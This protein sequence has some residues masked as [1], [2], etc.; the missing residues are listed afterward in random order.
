MFVAVDNI[1]R[2]GKNFKILD[3]HLSTEEY[4]IGFRKND[5]AYDEVQKQLLAMK[6]DGTLAKYQ[7]LG[8]EP[9]LV[10]GR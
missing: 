2:S 8:L 4:G 9:I 5:Q 7:L 6:A 1:E 3:E 10:V